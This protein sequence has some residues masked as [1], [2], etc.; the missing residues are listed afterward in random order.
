MRNIYTNKIVAEAINRARSLSKRGSPFA[1]KLSSVQQELRNRRKQF[2]GSYVPARELLLS[3]AGINDASIDALSR[4]L[5]AKTLAF[6]NVKGEDTEEFC[7][8]FYRLALY[9]LTGGK[10]ACECIDDIL[11]L[12]EC[13]VRSRDVFVIAMKEMLPANMIG[14]LYDFTESYSDEYYSVSF[15]DATLGGVCV[16]LGVLEDPLADVASES[17]KEDK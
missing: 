5:S 10:V 7:F 4:Y 1:D 15:E 2:L 12:S 17:S 11:R 8:R 16:F 3:D 14:E 13:L 6:W 9:A